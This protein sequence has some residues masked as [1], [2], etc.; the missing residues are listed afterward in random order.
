MVFFTLVSLST[1]DL[2]L[3]QLQKYNRETSYFKSAGIWSMLILALME[4]KTII[5]KGT[6]LKRF[7]MALFIAAVLMIAVAT[8]LNEGFSH[9]KGMTIVMLCLAPLM[10]MPFYHFLFGIL[11][12]NP[13]AIFATIRNF[14]LRG[15]LAITM[16]ANIIFIYLSHEP[17]LFNQFIHL[18]FTFSALIYIFYFATRTRAKRTHNNNHDEDLESGAPAFLHYLTILLE[19]FYYSI[20]IFFVFLQNLVT[21]YMPN[22]PLMIVVPIALALLYLA[23]ILVVKLLFIERSPPSLDF[24][25]AIILPLSFSYFGVAFIYQSFF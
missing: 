1:L 8:L 3:G 6:A 2:L 16:S 7:F 12:H 13:L 4:P 24:Y 25:E 15:I 23:I 21:V 22:Q 18:L 5:N 17:N 14:R 11:G 10:A 20:L 19:F 9:T